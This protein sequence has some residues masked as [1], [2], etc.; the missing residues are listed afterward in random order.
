MWLEGRAIAVQTVA[1]VL[2]D[3][4]CFFRWAEDAGYIARSPVPRRLLP[5]I[6]ER[7]PDRLTD[8]QSQLTADDLA[9]YADRVLDIAHGLGRQ[10]VMAGIS[11]GGV[12]TAWAAQY[13][14][15]LDVQ[16]GQALFPGLVTALLA[17][18]PLSL[19]SIRPTSGTAP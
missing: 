12:T 9:A 16:V 7:P 6:Q 19:Y 13:R 14:S 2:A 11:A 1:H 5:R 10:V 3:A 8:E 18:L 4:R 17:L 15:D